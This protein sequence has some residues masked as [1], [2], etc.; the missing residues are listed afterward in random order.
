MDVAAGNAEPD[1]ERCDPLK[2][3]DMAADRRY[4]YARA[5]A[6][7]GDWRVAAD[8]L[9]QALERAPHWSPAWFA[10]GQARERLAQTGEAAQAYAAALAADPQDRCGA[11]TRLALIDGAGA[12]H[13]LPRAYV[14][15]LFDDYAARFDEHLGEALAYRG[16]ALIVEALDAH[17]P[18]RRFAR[19][20]DLGC[21][22]GLAGQALRERVDTLVGVDLSPAMIAK[23]RQ[24]AIYDALC[25]GDIV[26]FLREG[27]AGAAD[28]IVAADVL[29]YV[30]DLS[31]LFVAAE[32]AMA[33]SGLLAFSLERSEGPGFQLGQ[34]SRFAHARAYVETAADA[35]G[36]RVASQSEVSTRREGGREVPGLVCLARKAP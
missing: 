16:P 31:A 24:K 1:R 18:R 7:D 21:G 30:G 5:A 13:K 15:R 19:C 32:R 2:S 10:L 20:V 35:A 9:E 25:V 6:A 23:A 27:R 8:L 26:D 14:A 22:T 28:L 29:V 4:E 34:G 33:P 36:L 11:G 17:A 3:G 12:A